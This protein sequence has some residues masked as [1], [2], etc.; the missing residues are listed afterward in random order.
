[1]NIYLRKDKRYTDLFFINMSLKMTQQ[2]QKLQVCSS[3]MWPSFKMTFH[4]S[5]L[6]FSDL[7]RPQLTQEASQHLL[8]CFDM[9][10]YVSWRLKLAPLCSQAFIVLTHS[11]NHSWQ[12][13]KKIC[14]S[15][16]VNHFI[17]SK[18]SLWY[19]CIY[20]FV[21]NTELSYN[22]TLHTVNIKYIIHLKHWILF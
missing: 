19:W 10:S 5:G 20:T 16:L 17:V 11:H 9:C 22:D 18:S 7:W 8:T 2:Y 3:L 12:G 21:Y 13:L 14:F 15:A 1:M 4:I 6:S